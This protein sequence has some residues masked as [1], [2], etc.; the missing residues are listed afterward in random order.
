MEMPGIPLIYNCLVMIPVASNQWTWRFV[1]SFQLQRLR[2]LHFDLRNSKFFNWPIQS[3]KTDDQTRA[4]LQSFAILAILSFR[5]QKLNA[6]HLQSSS[7]CKITLALVIISL[8]FKAFLTQLKWRD[9]VSLLFRPVY[10][11][12]WLV[13]LFRSPQPTFFRPWVML[14][15][16]HRLSG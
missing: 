5:W 14:D 8:D 10:F 2:T 3:W 12:A 9:T 11:L 16:P 4:T 1:I 15:D 7:S 13:N 6:V